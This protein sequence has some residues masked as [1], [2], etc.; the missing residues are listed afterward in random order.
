MGING[1]SKVPGLQR[2]CVLDQIGCGLYRF[3]LAKLSI[4]ALESKGVMVKVML[5]VFLLN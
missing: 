4:C 3:F 5:P 2:V 1:S